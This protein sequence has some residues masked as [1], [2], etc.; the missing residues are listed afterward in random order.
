MKLAYIA[1]IGLY[2]DWAHSVQIMKMCEAFALSH[3]DIEVELIVPHRAESFQNDP[4]AYY[5]IQSVFKITRVYYVDIFRGHPSKYLYWLRF[6]TFLISARLYLLFFAEY[7]VMYTRELYVGAFFRNVFIE[8]HSFPAEVKSFHNFF[9][10]PVLGFIVLTSFIKKR[11]ENHGVDSE[12]IIVAPDAVRLED[13]ADETPQLEIRRTLNLSQRDYIV[14]Y[15]GTLKTMGEEKGVATVIRALEFT[16]SDIYRHIKL[17]VVG[18]ERD[19]IEHYTQYAEKRGVADKII[20]RGKVPHRDVPLHLRACDCLVAPFPATE[21]YSYY[22]SPLKIFEYM[23]A[24]RPMIVTDLSS[25]REVLREGE[26]ALFVPPEDGRALANAIIT[27]SKNSDLSLYLA[28]E[29]KREVV[30]H[31]TWKKRAENILEFITDRV[32][33]SLENHLFTTSNETYNS[34]PDL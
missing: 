10:R 23:A 19:H 13:F 5:S 7:D 27:L 21:H 3:R 33:N 4:F 31:Y 32:K 11:F 34:D 22:M 15:V 30:L 24:E 29:A 26:T 17:Y 9:F 6:G 28:T 18:G 12:K 14:G 1:N 8:R 20:W 16:H 2:D 25:L